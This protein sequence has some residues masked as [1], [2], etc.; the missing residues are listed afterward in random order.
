MKYSLVLRNNGSCIA[1][2]MQ[3]GDYADSLKK[4]EQVSILM[5]LQI[6]VWIPGKC[7]AIFKNGCAIQP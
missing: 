1:L 3:C 5:G 6:E 7:C 4:A 2:A